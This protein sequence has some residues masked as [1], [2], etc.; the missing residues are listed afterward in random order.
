MIGLSAA[1]HGLVITGVARS[2]FHTSTP[3]AKNQFV[4]TIKII[5]TGTAPQKNAPGKMRENNIIEKAAEPPPEPVP[6]QKPDNREDPQEREAAQENAN[7]AGNNEE[8]REGERGAGNND[9]VRE[10]DAVGSGTITDREALLAYIKDFI[11]KNLAYPAMAR[12]RNIQGVVGVYFE[13]EESGEIAAIA[14][15]HSSGSSILDNAA[16]TLIKKINPKN[17]STKRKLA[18]NV[19]IDYRLN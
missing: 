16:V 18:L 7:A 13:I 8:S 3:A 9:E 19:N 14:V 2:G 6:V 17:I 4:S 11:D 15:N 5:Q 12:R 1:L 10:G